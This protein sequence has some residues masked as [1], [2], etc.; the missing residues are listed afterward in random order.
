MATKIRE[1]KAS[2]EN[3]Y[4][5]FIAFAKMFIRFTQFKCDQC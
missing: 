2:E 3:I 5:N 4:E 1:T